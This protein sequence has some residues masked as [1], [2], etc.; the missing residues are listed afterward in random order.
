VAAIAELAFLRPENARLQQWVASLTGTTAHDAY[1]PGY[2]TDAGSPAQWHPDPSGHHQLR[3]W[4]GANWS[5][6]VS[7]DGVA[8]SDPVNG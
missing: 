4:D 6:Q 1:T 7:D 3:W 5:D 8:S 2:T